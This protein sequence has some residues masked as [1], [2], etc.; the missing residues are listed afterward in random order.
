M[1]ERKH[2]HYFKDVSK[3]DV[4]DVY[5]VLVLFDV[6]DPCLQ[7]AAKK[8]MLAGSRGAGKDVSR[9]VQEVIDTLIRWQEMRI[10]ETAACFNDRARRRCD[11]TCGGVCSAGCA[12][13]WT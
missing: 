10:E 1:A 5:R 13:P 7:H 2:G 9:D 6:T 3:L 4:I 11:G 12:L 8:I